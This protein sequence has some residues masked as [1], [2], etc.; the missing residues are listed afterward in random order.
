MRV[1]ASIL[2]GYCR[3]VAIDKVWTECISKESWAIKIIFREIC[4]DNI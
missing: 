1:T 2:Y 3:Q 4:Q